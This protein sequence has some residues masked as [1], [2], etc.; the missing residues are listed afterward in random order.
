MSE[1]LDEATVQIN[2]KVAKAREEG[3]PA[4]SADEARVAEQTFLRLVEN[5]LDCV[6]EVSDPL[7]QVAL[8]VKSWAKFAERI[9]PAEGLT[10]IG[11]PVPQIQRKR[12]APRLGAGLAYD[13]RKQGLGRQQARVVVEARSIVRVERFA[14]E[15]FDDEPT[16]RTQV[17]SLLNDIA[18]QARDKDAWHLLVVA[19]VT[20]WT[21]E[22]EDFLQGKGTRSFRDRFV[23]VVLFRSDAA[24]FE[25]DDTDEKLLAFREAFAMNMDAAVL[26]TARRF[27]GDYLQ[28]HDSISLKT[29][30]EELQ[31]SRKAGIQVCRALATVGAYSFDVLDDLG[32]VLSRK[33]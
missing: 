6:S 9:E 2:K 1:P 23:S 28:L 10:N 31:I 21:A 20:G 13:L 8:H 14:K 7:R 29:L 15:G 19:S 3:K 25:Y 30:V 4:I 33:S 27:L 24:R 16:S 11:D 22:A 18:R 5:S 26:E 17:E 12:I 32:M